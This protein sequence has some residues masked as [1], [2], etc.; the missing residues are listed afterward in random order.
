V[1]FIHLLPILVDKFFFIVQNEFILRIRSLLDYIIKNNT[2][3]KET[4]KWERIA[5]LK[6]DR[7]VD[8]DISLMKTYRN[9]IFSSL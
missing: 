1:F 5:P 2:F 9:W 3:I 7:I 4:I 6:R 8:L